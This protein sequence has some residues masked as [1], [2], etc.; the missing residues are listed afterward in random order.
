[1]HK[2]HAGASSELIRAKLTHHS[3]LLGAADTRSVHNAFVAVFFFFQCTKLFNARRFITSAPAWSTR[4]CFLELST[5]R[6]P[7]YTHQHSFHVTHKRHVLTVADGSKQPKRRPQACGPGATSVTRVLATTSR[8]AGMQLHWTARP[9]NSRCRENCASVL[10]K[11][12]GACGP[13]HPQNALWHGSYW[14][15]RW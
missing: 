10:Y 3:T 7:I 1:V 13:G 9:A 14:C 12:A 4:S 15:C 6:Q 2:M 5:S 11:L 8:R